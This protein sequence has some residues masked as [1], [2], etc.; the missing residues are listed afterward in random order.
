VVVQGGKHGG[1]RNVRWE[2]CCGVVVMFCERH[3]EGWREGGFLAVVTSNTEALNVGEQ[4]NDGGVS[5]GRG[6]PPS[7]F[8]ATGISTESLGTRPSRAEREAGC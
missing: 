4:I 8:A 2:R 3:G 7:G 6:R 1:G 5:W